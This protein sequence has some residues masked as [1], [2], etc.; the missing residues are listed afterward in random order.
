MKQTNVDVARCYWIDNAKVMGLFFM[1]IGHMSLLSPI[2]TQIIYSF[3][4][5]LFFFLSGL[6][7]KKTKNFKEQFKKGFNR[8]IIPYILI[9]GILLT[10]DVVINTIILHNGWGGVKNQLVAIILGLGFGFKGL[11]P[12]CAPS[13]FLMS[14]FLIQL[15]SYLIVNQKKLTLLVCVTSIFINVIIH[16]LSWQVISPVSVIMGLPFF[17]MGFL[18]DDTM[19]SKDIFSKLYKKV[20][21][22]G[23]VLIM[24]TLAIITIMLSLYNGRIECCKV[25][26]GSNILLFYVN[27]M[28]GV[29]S[30]VMF[31]K[32]I[33]PVFRKFVTIICKGTLFVLGFHIFIIQWCFAIIHKL[34][35]TFEYNFKIGVL[36]GV[37]FLIMSY[38]VIMF[39]LYYFP[40]ILGYSKKKKVG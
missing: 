3:H 29:F 30:V 4:M 10:I 25:D 8:L 2:P 14:L 22:V 18:L 13:W 9:N 33:G 5:P 27:A 35:P 19:I 31:S 37:I 7:F 6:L 40:E 12:V 1:I 28:I 21:A 24:M 15:I 16:H 34:W 32:L 23:Y 36:I 39:L 26:Y 20:N 38:S 17:C 11:R